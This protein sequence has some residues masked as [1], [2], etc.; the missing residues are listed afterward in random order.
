VVRVPREDGYFAPSLAPF[1]LNYRVGD[2]DAMLAQ[3]R[4]AEAQVEERIEEHD[5]GRFGCASDQK[6]TVLSCGSR[7]KAKSAQVSED[8]AGL[9]TPSPMYRKDASMHSRPRYRVSDVGGQE[10]GG[11]KSAGVATS[12]APLVVRPA[13]GHEPSRATGSW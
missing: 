10:Q 7:A 8:S 3:L 2:L 12:I 6:A 13:V 4:A 9:R 1:M 11:R 5:Y